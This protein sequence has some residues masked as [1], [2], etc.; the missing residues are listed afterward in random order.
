M[1]PLLSDEDLQGA[2]VAGLLR[3]FPGID[4]IRVQDV[5]LMRTP[6]PPHPGLCRQSESRHR[7]A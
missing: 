1:L 7:H 4:L 6:D 5:G 2:I 3:N